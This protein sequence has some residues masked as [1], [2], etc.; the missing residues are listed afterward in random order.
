[1]ALATALELV[2]EPSAVPL[3]KAE[4]SQAKA[5]DMVIPTLA[6]TFMATGLSG[7]T[8]IGMALFVMFD[9]NVESEW[10]GNGSASGIAKHRTICK[11]YRNRV[12]SEFDVGNSTVSETWQANINHPMLIE[13]G[14]VQDH[15]ETLEINLP[16]IKK[17]YK[18]RKENGFAIRIHRPEP[19]KASTLSSNKDTAR[20]AEANKAVKALEA[21]KGMLDQSAD[22]K[23]PALKV[24]W[25]GPDDTSSKSA[26]VELTESQVAKII[27]GAVG[28]LRKYA[29]TLLVENQ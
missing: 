24:Q 7:Q 28:I 25:R 21:V 6:E 9:A 19:K 2:T 15:G 11:E 10:M 4:I 3:T 14:A 8:A 22:P 13:M 27:A 12:M 1:M 5:A 16:M 23:G 29:P 20:I 18:E 26:K 17:V